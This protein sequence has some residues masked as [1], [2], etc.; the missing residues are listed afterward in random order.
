MRS[1]KWSLLL[2]LG[3][4]LT[5]FLAAC[6]GGGSEDDGSGEGD[7]ENTED[8]SGTDG[9]E[10]DSDKEA[11][12]GDNET[13]RLIE[14]SEIP[15]M[16][17]SKVQTST[18]IQF[19]TAVQEGLYRLAPGG[20]IVDGVAKKS[21]TEVSEDGLTWTFHLRDNATWANGDNVTAG[22]FV[23]A[24]Q[25]AIN[26]DTGSVYGPYLMKGNIKNATAIANGEME[27][28]ELGVEAKDEQTLVVNLET[29][30][31]YFDSFAAFPTFY[32]LH[33]EFVEEQGENYALEADTILSNGP[34][35]MESWD[36]GS[37]WKL[38]KNED[39]WDAS[40]VDLEALDV[41]V[42][43]ERATQVN[44]YQT[45][46]V[47]KA[48]LGGDF[49][50]KYKT[51][52]DY[53][54]LQETVLFYLKFNQDSATQGEKMQNENFRKAIAQG[55]NKEDY[56]NVVV[57]NS[58][59]PAN[60]FI[61][62]GLD[63]HPETDEGFRDINGEMLKFDLEKAQEHWSKAK[64]ELGFEEV[65]LSF[66]SG[67]TES[68]KLTSEFFKNQL[69]KN[70]PGLTIKLKQVP[71]KERVRIEN[72]SEYELTFSGWGPDYADAM[73]FLDLW[74]TGGPNNDMGY[75][76]EEYDKLINQARTDLATKPVERFE[77]MLEA[78]KVLLDDA[79]IAPVYQRVRSVLQKPYVK[80]MDQLN[81]FGND[82]SYKFVEIEK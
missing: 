6:S 4:V 70:L 59:I 61:P 60:Y 39:Y 75:S 17:A 47:D 54:E 11:S 33:K 51:D 32:P 13:L 77:A 30:V 67:D 41:R 8:N 20:D 25:R 21:E 68:A 7:G 38:V 72:A 37:S 71:F 76:N 9:G 23:Y 1:T 66:L 22:D 57:G 62:T 3:L 52:S 16:D 46:K 10:G 28:S 49:I 34:F 19:V 26:P 78:E 69:E 82:Y 40:N 64:E 2:V 74:V 31:P 42:V 48:G 50:D 63:K 53:K 44:L 56:V 18:G 58:S 45:G 5:M 55:F 79:A 73:T 80:N 65:E 12:G 43:K 27:P 29:P 36:H 14:G 24:W 81:P 35:K 15:S